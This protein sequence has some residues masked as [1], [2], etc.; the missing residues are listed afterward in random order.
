MKSNL[1]LFFKPINEYYGNFMLFN[2]CT[3][4]G[5]TVSMVLN[6]M[7]SKRTFESFIDQTVWTNTCSPCKQLK[8]KIVWSDGFSVMI[9]TQRTTLKLDFIWINSNNWKQVRHRGLTELWQ[10]KKNLFEK[11][12]LD[13]SLL[14]WFRYSKFNSVELFSRN[15][16]L[17]IFRVQ[18]TWLNQE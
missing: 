10:H 3:A 7:K 14:S 1:V 5:T 13:I 16:E 18:G 17:S 8:W 15:V 2:K 9:C 4:I 11:S 12:L 6:C